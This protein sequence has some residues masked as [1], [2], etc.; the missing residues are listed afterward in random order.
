MTQEGL[1]NLKAVMRKA[2]E[3]QVNAT[4]VMATLQ[5]IYC[6]EEDGLDQ[7]AEERLLSAIHLVRMSMNYV[8]ETPREIQKAYGI[9]KGLAA[10]DEMLDK[11]QDNDKE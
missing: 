7:D 1:E 2:I 9:E 10:L 3:L 11:E 8:I 4:L 5:S 6:D